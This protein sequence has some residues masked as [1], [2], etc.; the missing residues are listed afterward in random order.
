MATKTIRLAG[1]DDEAVVF[2]LDYNDLNNRA[3]ALR[4]TNNDPQGRPAYGSVWRTSDGVK[5]DA[6]FGPGVT[7]V[8]IPTVVASRI[9]L[10]RIGA[11]WDGYEGAFEF[12]WV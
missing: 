5:Y 6:R 4:C 3:T 10:T 9:Q 2:E 8:V 7:Q 1:F 11:H 12:P